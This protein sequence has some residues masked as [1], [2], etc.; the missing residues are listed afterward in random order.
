M[1]VGQ[2][3]VWPGT[4]A[5]VIQAAEAS[6]HPLSHHR[7]RGSGDNAGRWHVYTFCCSLVRDT[8]KAPAI[9]DT[10]T[11]VC[12]SSSVFEYLNR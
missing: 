7:E 4:P 1:F 8:P 10:E 6:P 11:P 2:V 5:V 12:I 9:W 3:R